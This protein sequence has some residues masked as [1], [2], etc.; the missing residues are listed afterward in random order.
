MRAR[1]GAIPPFAFVQTSCYSGRAKL[2]NTAMNLAAIQKALREQGVDAWLF[3]DHHHRDAIAYSILGLPASMHCTRRWFYVI[4]AEG[5]PMKLNHSVEPN[6]LKTLPGERLI[7]GSWQQLSQS[8][9]TLLAPYKSVAMQYSPNNQIMYISLVDG[10]TIELIR[11]LGLDVVSSADLVSQFEAVLTDEQIE[12]HFAAQRKVDGII[13]EAFKTIGERVR[14]GGWDEYGVQQW[15]GEA[16][17]RE[18]L[19]CD[20]LPIVGCNENSGDCHY[21]PTREGSKPIHAGDWVL[22]DV[23]AKLKKPGAVY[24]D[25]TWTGFIGDNPPEKIQQVFE[26]VRDARDIGLKTADEAF[27]AGRRLEG[28]EVDDAVR[29]HISA[30][31]YGQYFV[32]RT[33]HSIG[34]EVHGNGANMDN[35]E[36]HDVRRVLN[37]TIFSMEPGIYLPE[38]GVRSEFDIL[39]RDGKAIS[40]GRVQKEIVLI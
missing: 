4:P 6:H 14:R 34:H 37:N 16:F 13:A 29:R 5:E 7:Y 2:Y 30:H 9:K 35:L 26:I 12:T 10:G 36:T 40:T 33:G 39:A 18:G 11:S 1:A 31:G 38:F 20:D 22:L 25:V 24:Y 28:W 3:C 21:G 27:R 32:H 19:E 8:L 23:W 15:F 17:E